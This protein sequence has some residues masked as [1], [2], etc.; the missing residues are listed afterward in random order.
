[1]MVHEG[2]LETENE[3]GVLCRGAGQTDEVY[4]LRSVA[5]SLQQAFERYYIAIAIL[6]KNGPGTVTATE[7]ELLCQ[8]TAQRLSLLYAPSAPEFFDRT[9]F[10]GFIQ[11]LRELGIVWLDA[12]ARLDFDE[13]LHEWASDA[14]V[15]LGR[16][17]RHTIIKLSPETLGSA[18]PAS[19]PESG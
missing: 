4:R 10:R 8:L 3:Q 7:L 18:K 15:I 2:L 9:L 6:V 19:P 13:R 16:E 1:M 11:R 17:V 5:Q 14:K 12:N